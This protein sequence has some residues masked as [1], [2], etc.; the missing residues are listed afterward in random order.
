MHQLTS[1]FFLKSSVALGAVVFIAL[2][3][4]C[5]SNSPSSSNAAPGESPASN[6]NSA[7]NPGSSG[8]G[9]STSNKDGLDACKLVTQAEAE[10]ALGQAV[11]PATQDAS[12]PNRS[13]CD[14]ISSDNSGSPSSMCS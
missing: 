6:T 2:F 4:A 8:G 10:Q 14:Y 1:R 3:A 11:E 5:S 13:D 7:A 12:T 9:S